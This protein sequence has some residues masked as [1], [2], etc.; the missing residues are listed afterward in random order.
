V[1]RTFVFRSEADIRKSGK[2]ISR[3]LLGNGK[4]RLIKTSRAFF[5]AWA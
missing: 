3:K 4:F 2:P 5:L 1:A